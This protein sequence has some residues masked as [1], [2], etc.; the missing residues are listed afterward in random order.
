MKT[1][2]A[3]ILLVVLALSCLPAGADENVSGDYI[4]VEIKGTLQTGMMAI[5]G[6]TTGTIIRANNVQWELDLG[7]NAQLQANAEKLDGKSV[8][9]TGRYEKRKGVEIRERHIVKVETLKA[10]GR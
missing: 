2:I 3:S 8:V 1:A 7:G 6:E 10:A 5:G 4:K 9:V